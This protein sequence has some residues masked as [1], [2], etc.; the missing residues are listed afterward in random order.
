M[1]T[2]IPAVFLF[3]LAP[4]V[5]CS[6][7][8]KEIYTTE[9]AYVE[10]L[11]FVIENYRN[12]M[13]EKGIISKKDLETLFFG[14]EDILVCNQIFLLKIRKR[15]EKWNLNSQLGDLFTELVSPPPSF[16]T[17]FSFSS[18][19]QNQLLLGGDGAEQGF[20]QLHQVCEQL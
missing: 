17:L 3:F 11:C 15:T 13:A 10:S 19:F 9:K 5:K 4:A 6:Y 14:L 12:Q 20:E 1:T 18:T 2:A 16:P 8:A 7:I